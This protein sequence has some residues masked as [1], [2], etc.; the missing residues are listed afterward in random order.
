MIRRP[1]RSTLFPYTTLF[2]SLELLDHQAA[3]E[4]AQLAALRARDAVRRILLRHL[5]EAGTGAQRDEQRFR[6]LQRAGPRRRVGL[7]DDDD[8]PERDRR[9][10]LRLLPPVRLPKLVHLRIG[11]RD[12]PQLALAL[13][14]FDQ[15]LLQDR[16]ALLVGE[17]APPLLFGHEPRGL[18]LRPDLRDGRELLAHVLDRLLHGF[19]DFLL[20]HPDGGVALRLLHHQRSEER[21]VWKECRSRWSPYH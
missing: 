20:R 14:L 3:P 19:L 7:R 10:A 21:R 1:P 12:R 16:A 11:R 9:R 13:Q 2:R 18:K 4:P 6:E 17:P 15:P 5:G 8:L